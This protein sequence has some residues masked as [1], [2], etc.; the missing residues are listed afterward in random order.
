MGI[1]SC[2]AQ[3][4]GRLPLITRRVRN[5]ILERTPLLSVWQVE[6]RTEHPLADDRPGQR[7]T[8][9]SGGVGDVRIEF[10]QM[11]DLRHPGHEKRRACE[12]VQHEMSSPV[13]PGADATSGPG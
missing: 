7:I 4:R 1:N 11:Q 13:R 2:S 6:E 3:P 12:P 10:E 8:E 5:Q 9:G